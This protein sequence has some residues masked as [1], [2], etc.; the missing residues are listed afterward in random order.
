MVGTHLYKLSRECR[1]VRARIRPLKCFQKFS[2]KFPSRQKILLSRQ[3]PLS[4]YYVLATHLGGL[5]S[6][7]RPVR[8]RLG[9][10]KTFSISAKNFAF[11]PAAPVILNYA[12]NTLGGPKL[13]WAPG[14]GTAWA[15]KVFSKIFHLGKNFCFRASCYCAFLMCWQHTCGA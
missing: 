15:L 12:G 1:Q 6:H 4:F 10:S 5:N 14:A 8:A 9:P 13:T 3:L 11:A 2:K 7:R